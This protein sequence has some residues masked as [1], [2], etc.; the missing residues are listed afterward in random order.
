M[1]SSQGHLVGLRRLVEHPGVDGC[2][3]QVIG[4]CDGMNVTSQMEVELKGKMGHKEEERTQIKKKRG[5]GIRQNKSI[6]YYCIVVVHTV[7]L[8]GP[9]GNNTSNNGG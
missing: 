2:S 1:T 7:G 5:E 6:H 3:H 9:G 8:D 4:C